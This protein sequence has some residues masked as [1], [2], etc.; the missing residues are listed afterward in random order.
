[1]QI[2]LPLQKLN[3]QPQVLPLIP[4]F[5]VVVLQLAALAFHQRLTVKLPAGNVWLVLSIRIALLPQQHVALQAVILAFHAQLRLTVAAIY[6]QRLFVSL[7]VQQVY[8]SHALQILIAHY[9]RLQS[10]M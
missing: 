2:V 8:V 6:L 10:V 7:Q 5:H 3:A 1:M 4:V 9:L